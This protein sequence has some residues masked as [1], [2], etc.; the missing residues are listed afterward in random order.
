[1]ENN[2]AAPKK[3][4]FWSRSSWLLKLLIISA[5]VLAFE[6]FLTKM[7][8]ATWQEFSTEMYSVDHFIISFA[9]KISPV[10]LYEGYKTNHERYRYSMYFN[11]FSAPFNVTKA[12]ID[13]EKRVFRPP[14]PSLN[15]RIKN[16]ADEYF[17]QVKENDT[18]R[19]PYQANEFGQ[20]FY[21]MDSQLYNQESAHLRNACSFNLRAND[22]VNETNYSRS[23]FEWLFAIP[24]SFMDWIVGIWRHEDRTANWPGRVFLTISLLFALVNTK[25]IDKKGKEVSFWEIAFGFLGRFLIAMFLFGIVMLIIGGIMWLVL[26]V[27]D[28]ATALTSLTFGTGLFARFVHI[29]RTEVR[30]HLT[31]AGKDK[32]A[33]GVIKAGFFRS[34]VRKGK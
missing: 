4:N 1:M 24:D 12:C 15:D 7:K 28:A 10:A 23:V 33:E 5:F 34:I 9:V 31:F 16:V 21:K 29:F 2:N 27:G 8:W 20:P 22:P 3:G 26:F 13:A 25:S 30:E 11:K 18:A 14:P 17:D 32:I 6:S 19:L